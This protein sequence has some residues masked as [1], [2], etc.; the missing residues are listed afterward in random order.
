MKFMRFL[1]RILPLF[2]L[3]PIVIFSCQKN[4]HPATTGQQ[5]QTQTLLMNA[6]ND[7]VQASSLESEDVEDIMGSDSDSSCKVVTYVPSQN[8]YPYKKFV[9]YGPGCTGTDGITRK[10]KKIVTFFVNPDKASPGTMFS[11]T[12]YSDFYVDGIHVTGNVQSYMA[13]SSTMANH[14]IKNVSDKTLTASNGDSK[15]FIATNYWKQTEGMNTTTRKDDVF[16]ITGNASGTEILDGETD[17]KWQS[18][19]DDNHPVIKPVDCG[20]RTQGKVDVKLHIVTGGGSDFTEVLDYGDGSCDNKATL[21]INGGIP[22]DIT[23][24]L[25]FWPLSL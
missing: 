1:W 15:N 2:V 3:V 5:S 9:D 14:V 23:L 4:D 8:V 7:V 24:P 22:Q 21:S 20:Y 11:E 10:G 13:A 6:T 18:T 19:I 17:I 25:Y 16:Q 12:T